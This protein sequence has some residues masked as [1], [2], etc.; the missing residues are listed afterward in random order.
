VPSEEEIARDLE[1]EVDSLKAQ[2]L[3]SRSPLPETIDAL[4]NGLHQLGRDEEA[5]AL[6]QAQV[7]DATGPSKANLQQAL[8][9]VLGSLIDAARDAG[10]ADDV[11]LYELALSRL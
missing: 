9:K 3:A 10:E 1:L 4:V 5:Y 8:R 6:L 11:E 7:D 2:W